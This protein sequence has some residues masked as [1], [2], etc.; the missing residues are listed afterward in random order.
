MTLEQ[1]GDL[2][3]AQQVYSGEILDFSVNINP[4]GP[5]P[6]A[7][8]AARAAM[9]RAGEYPDPLC[10]ALRQAIAARDGV[11]PEQVLYVG[12]SGTDMQ[13]A[14]NAGLYAVGVTWGFRSEKEL[15]EYHADRI[16]N[17]A[18]DIYDIVKSSVE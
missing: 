14:K 10:R 2:F 11:Q 15:N 18:S 12:D 1:G 3:A 17:K 13:T 5:A 8:E 6:Q 7:L 9:E 16:V 4:M